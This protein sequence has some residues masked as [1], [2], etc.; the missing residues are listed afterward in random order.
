MRPVLV[1][2]LFS[3]F[4]LLS[5]ALGLRT[6]PECNS[7]P[8][9]T[10]DAEK[11]RC[12]SEAAITMAYL[13]GSRPSGSFGPCSEAVNICDAIWNTYGSPYDPNGQQKDIRRKAELVSNNCYFEVAKITRNSDTCGFITRRDDFGTALL[14]DEVTRDMCYDETENLA[15]IAPENYYTLNP[16]NICAL[17]YILPL[18]VIGVIRGKR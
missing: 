3:S 9:L 1:L 17:V 5:G 6:V 18:F 4:L 10:R 16:N 12:Y 2:M 14:G 7:D 8:S 15:K 11:M 13:C